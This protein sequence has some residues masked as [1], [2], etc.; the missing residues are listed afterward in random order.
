MNKHTQLLCFQHAGYHRGS[1]QGSLQ[2]VPVQAK[3]VFP[4]VFPAP[5]QDWVVQPRD[6][7][8][9]DVLFGQCDKD[10]KGIVQGKGK[11]FFV[12]GMKTDGVDASF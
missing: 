8:N 9:Y 4:A 7:A 10:K 12:F 6:K 1:L 5:Q 2:A 11:F 3:P